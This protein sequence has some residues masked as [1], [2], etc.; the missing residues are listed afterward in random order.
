MWRKTGRQIVLTDRTGFLREK[1]DVLSIEA[2]SIR[3]GGEQ[4]PRYLARADRV[5]VELIPDEPEAVGLL[6]LTRLT[7]ARRSARTADDDSLVRLADQDRSLWDRN[8]VEERQALVRACLRRHRPGSYQLHAAIAALHADAPVATDTDWGQILALYD[9]LAALTSS[10]VV[11]LN[12]AVAVGEV[13]GPASAL[14]L[15]EGP[16]LDHYHP[17]HAA[18]VTFLERLGHRE[19]AAALR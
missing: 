2:F 17:Y 16:A 15:I 3:V 4:R 19:L 1:S 6:A 11:A 14:G 5:L 7:Q 13:Q 10:P 12:R 8:L 18:L 9:Q